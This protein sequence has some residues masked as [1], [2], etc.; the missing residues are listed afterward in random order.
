MSYD[1]RSDRWLAVSVTKLETALTVSKEQFTGIVLIKAANQENFK[2]C[3]V[4][5]LSIQVCLPVVSS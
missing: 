1:Y 3:C 5:Q 4:C 2:V